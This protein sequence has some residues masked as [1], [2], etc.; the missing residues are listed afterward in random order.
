M[1]SFSD[2]GLSTNTLA[3]VED[4]GYTEPT[5]VQQQAIPLILEG[6]D[7]IAAAKTGTGKTGG[8]S[9]P[10]LDRLGHA[11]KGT[12]P[13]MLVITPTRELAQQIGDVCEAIARHTRH[14][15]AIV[16]GGLSYGPQI[17]RIKRGCD[18]LIATPGRLIDLMDQHAVNLKA[19]ETLV[20]DEADRMLDMGFLPAVKK[21]VAAT[22]KS[23]Q[24][25]LFSAT[26]DRSIMSTVNTMLHDP[27]LVE[28]AHKG[29]V[30]DT[31]D[32]FII[33]TPQTVKP[34]LVKAVLEEK[35]AERVIIF[36]RTRSRA[37]STARRL[38]R[39]GYNVEAIHSD[40]SQNQ[41][42][43]ALDRFSA[44]EVNILTATDVLARGIDVTEVDYVINYD[45]PTQPEDY[46][47]RIG[48][49]GRAGAAGFSV[50]FVTPETEDALKDIQ[51][52]IKQDIP[53]MKLASFDFSE[54]EAEAA[55]KQMEF[56]AKRDP[57]IAA[58]K[59]ELRAKAQRKAH[60]REAASESAPAKGRSARK[61]P[62]ATRPKPETGGKRSQGRAQVRGESAGGT[63]AKGRGTAGDFRPGRAQRAAAARRRTRS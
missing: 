8:F 43:R 5:P 63:A 31:I 45:L 52:L 42:K 29:D 3:A 46:V 53:E 40:R 24:T 11:K 57:E 50:S 20:L 38:K 62:T 19:V 35:G 28:I 39:A 30:A 59:K 34:S 1:K 27:A 33:R 44:G 2:L 60:K 23:R 13:L 7:V 17:E 14:H 21:I 10:S 12:G 4:M 6:H 9:L 26:I 25:L 56:Q 41:R 54:A 51:K 36:A 18:V 47:H 48:R 49:T 61:K 32:Q 58:A 15:I 37:D 22:P 55:A 16:V